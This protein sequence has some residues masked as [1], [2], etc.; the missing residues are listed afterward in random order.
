MPTKF[1][2]QL[3]QKE[4][5]FMGEMKVAL[6]TAPPFRGAGSARMVVL[7]DGS[8]GLAES[9]A[10]FAD[11]YRT[12]ALGQEIVARAA[13]GDLPQDGLDFAESELARLRDE[14]EHMESVV[15]ALRYVVASALQ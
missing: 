4:V 11:S 3:T 7:D 12:R 10:F 9:S 15:D 1:A 8:F 14:L 13:H 5:Q 2:V 6:H